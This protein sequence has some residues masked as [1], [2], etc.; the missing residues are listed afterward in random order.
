MPI[1]GAQELS[2]IPY[3]TRIVVNKGSNCGTREHRPNSAQRRRRPR[4]KSNSIPIQA[5]YS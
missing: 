2:G 3:F 1:T 5:I 4:S